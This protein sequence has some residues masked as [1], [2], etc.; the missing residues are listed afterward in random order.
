MVRP[1]RYFL[2]VSVLLFGWMKSSFGLN[3][4]ETDLVGEW[5]AYYEPATVLTFNEDLT[6]AYD[7]HDLQFEGTWELVE[8]EILDGLLII[9]EE[10]VVWHFYTE[11]VATVI[12]LYP[13][14]DTEKPY[15]FVK[16]K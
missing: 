8:T 16:R 13:D 7:Y 11:M 3:I 15:I 9:W 1:F 2:I 10:R 4:Q 12:Y 14:L 6:C 5:Y